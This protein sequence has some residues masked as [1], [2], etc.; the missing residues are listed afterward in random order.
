MIENI[1]KKKAVVFSYGTVTAANPALQK[2]RVRLRSDLLIWVRT[3]LGLSA[4]DT[5]IV[6]R[7]DKDSSWFI[8]Q[9]SEKAVPSQ[10]TLLLI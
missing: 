10:G 1:L 5:V 9:H 4:G 2:V 8:V 6:A 7:N 3:T